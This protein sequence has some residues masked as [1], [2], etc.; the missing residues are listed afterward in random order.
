[1][2]W[3]AGT[4]L[5]AAGLALGQWHGAFA[6]GWRS[7]GAGS[8]GSQ[9]AYFISPTGNDSAGN[10][11]IG[12]PWATLA[13]CKTQ[14]ESSSVALCYARSGTYTVSTML[15]LSSADNGFTF[16][17]YP[18]DGYDS[19]IFDFSGQTLANPSQVDAILISGGNDI[20]INGLTIKNPAGGGI[21]IHGGGTYFDVGTQWGSPSSYTYLSTANAY[22]NTIENCVIFG[23]T[24]GAIENPPYPTWLGL[25]NAWG[26]VQ[27]TTIKNNIVYSTVW[28]GISAGTIADNPSPTGPAGGLD[29]LLIENN[30]VLNTSTTNSGINEDSAGIYVVDREAQPGAGGGASTNIQVLHN[31]VRDS[32]FVASDGFKGIYLDDWTSGATVAYNVVAGLSNWALYLHGGGSDTYKYNVL[33]LGA[34]NNQAAAGIQAEP[35]QTETTKTCTGSASGTTTITFSGC[36]ATPASNDYF[37]GTGVVQPAEISSCGTFSGGAGTC[38]GTA[39]QTF[40]SITVTIGN[41]CAVYGSSTACMTGNVF[42]SNIIIGNS[43]GKNQ[44]LGYQRLSA[45]PTQPTV[46]NNLYYNYFNPP[47][48]TMASGIDSNPTNGNPL[49]SGCWA[50][51]GASPA[52]SSPINF[53]AGTYFGPWGPPGYGPIT[54]TFPVTGTMPSYGSPSC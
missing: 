24:Q 16:S 15:T 11:T 13:K 48:T 38:T 12:N 18:A 34:N 27:N 22:G 4:A 23:S 33:D 43:N 39:D 26:A 46:E 17:Y 1:M 7:T 50:L 5:L 28:A 6:W 9:Q 51:S 32:Q 31:L 14:M 29:N 8:V 10:G 21:G 41:T 36:S 45:V 20:T 47:T 37:S 40:G 3:R 19:A 35:P 52:F 25:I 42:E 53:P 49:L 44:G 2:I 54:G 30:A